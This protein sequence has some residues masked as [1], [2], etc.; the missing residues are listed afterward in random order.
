MVFNLKMLEIRRLI[1]SFLLMYKN[2]CRNHPVIGSHLY[3]AAIKVD[4]ITLQFS[5]VWK[6]WQVYN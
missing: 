6:L 2:S 3:T 1:N 5:F 4:Y